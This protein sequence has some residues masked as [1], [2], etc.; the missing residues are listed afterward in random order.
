[1]PIGKKLQPDRTVALRGFDNLGAAAALHGASPSGFTVS[2]VFRDPSDFAVLILYDA[3]NFYEHLRIK[4]LPDFDFSGVVLTFDMEMEG[5]QP[6]D[7]NK[8]PTIDWPFLDVIRPDGSTARIRLSDNATV[9][10]GSQ[11]K[12]SHSVS[13]IAGDVAAYDRLT[14]W[15]QNY[16]FD[17]IAQGGE[18]SAQVAS[19][20]AAMVNA[21]AFPPGYGISASVSGSS[22]TFTSR[23]AGEDGNHVAMYATWKNDNLKLSE[24][25]WRLSGGSSSVTWR[26]RL[27]FSAL[28][29]D[30]IRL[31]WLT[32]APKLAVAAEY[33]AT[34][35][36]ARFSNWTI[37]DPNGVANLHVASSGSVIVSSEDPSWVKYSGNWSAEFGFY[38]KGYARRA[39][40]VGDSVTVRYWCQYQ[41]ELWLGTALYVD[42]GIVSVTVDDMDPVELD[43]YLANEPQVITRRRIGSFV[44]P[45]GMH[46]VKITLIGQNPAAIGR[47][48]Y[49]DYLQAVVRGDPPPPVESSQRLAPANDYGTDHGYKLSPQR[50]MWMMDQLGYHGE[51][52][53]YV[54]VFWWNQRKAVGR[55]WPEARITFPSNL[56][57][58]D[59]IFID[60]GGSVFGKSVFP[61]DTPQTIAYHFAAFISEVSVGVWARSDG[62]TLYIRPR[63]IAPAYEFPISC[64]V[65]R[66]STTFPLPV[67]G[68]LS[69][70]QPGQWVIDP[71]QDPPI[72]VAS[73]KWLEDLCRE[74]VKR[75]RQLVLAYSM[76]LLYPPDD[77]AAGEVWASRYPDGTPVLTDTGFASHKTTHCTFSRP[78]LEYQKRVYEQTAEIMAAAGLPV[79]LQFGEFL[80]WFFSNGS[81]MAFYDDYT[82]QAAL[83]RL[84]RPLAMFLTPDDDPS[85]NG[86]ADAN[87]LAALLE[88]H[89]REIRDHVRSRFPD[90]RFELLLALDVNAPRP[91]G[92][93]NLGGRL[94]HA[95]NIPAS[96]RSPGAAPFDLL[97][98]EALNFG[99]WSFDLNLARAAMRWYRVDASWPRQSVRYNVPVF[100]GAAP[101]EREYWEAAKEGIPQIMLWA[102]DHICLFSLPGGEPTLNDQAI[103][104]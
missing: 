35:W 46:R 62:P 81:G 7:S 93:Y 21:A 52:N 14:I 61:Q 49:F 44:L 29:I 38:E 34:E 9:V 73:R 57:P 74:Y 2:G 16:A 45:P 103:I 43:C 65:E 23:A 18:T 51:G 70:G 80:W 10:A 53:V 27:D 54:S 41:H 56:Q 104:L 58:D 24:S 4:Y 36:E 68:S 94:N 98:I 75:G 87:F 82:K 12:A 50:L 79:L 59:Q 47:Y 78:V 60:L 40:E 3:D 48:F 63:A 92:R 86:Y 17:Y 32:F 6:I 89:C 64:R 90:S 33:Q 84:G 66:G 1:M 67:D 8:Y 5:L 91:S 76:E 88:N 95:V 20:I 13:V 26:V 97:K 100:R 72:N 96:F 25:S 31:A 28:G 69:G 39:S 11:V 55:V 37:D 101:W 15:Y 22:I 77:P 85:V 102:F 71:E 42:R 30:R 19:A 83:A 99:A